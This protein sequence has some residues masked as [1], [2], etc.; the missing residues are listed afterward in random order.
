MDI[1]WITP[2]Q[3]ADLESLIE[4]VQ[5]DRRKFL[6]YLHAETIDKIRASEFSRAVAAL[7]HKRG[8]A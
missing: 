1:E 3:A 7:E 6:K 2:E 5:A 8:A 4:E